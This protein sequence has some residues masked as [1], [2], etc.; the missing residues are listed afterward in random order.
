MYSIFFTK[1]KNRSSFSQRE[2]Q[3]CQCPCAWLGCSVLGGVWKISKFVFL[4]EKKT[5]T[6]HPRPPVAVNCQKKADCLVEPFMLEAVQVGEKRIQLW[7][8]TDDSKLSAG[9][10]V[11]IL[12]SCPRHRLYHMCVCYMCVCLFVVLWLFICCRLFWTV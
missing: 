5:K 9:C 7:Y 6:K 2:K 1:E 4:M 11:L 8:L 12:C 3:S 10:D